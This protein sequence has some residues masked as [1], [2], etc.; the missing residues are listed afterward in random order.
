MKDINE[1]IAE[2]QKLADLCGWNELNKAL[3]IISEL[4]KQVNGWQPIETAP[5]DST[6]VLIFSEK[7]PDK[8]IIIGWYCLDFEEWRHYGVGGNDSLYYI[9]SHW[10]PLPSP[11]KN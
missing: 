6:Q 4:Q 8:E 1:R 10:M 3:E 11:P 2:F 7:D 5:R 9:P